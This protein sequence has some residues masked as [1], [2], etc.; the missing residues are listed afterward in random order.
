MSVVPKDVLK[1]T[2]PTK[3]FLC[4]L[5]DNH[6]G[7]EFLEFTIQDYD[8]KRVIFHVDRD[9]S[10]APDFDSSSNFDAD[11]L[12][13]IDYKFESDV[14]MLPRVQ[15]KL[16]FKVGRKKVRQF[17]MIERHYFRNRLIKSFD[18]TFPFCVPGSTNTWYSEYEL[19]P[20]DNALID[21]I[22]KRPYETES[23][24]FYF[25]GN[26]LIMHNKARYHYFHTEATKRRMEAKSGGGGG[27]K[28][29]GGAAA[30]ATAAASA[31]VTDS[32]GGGK[33]DYDDDA[34][35][36]ADYDEKADKFSGK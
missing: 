28:T 34:G 6:V 15:T 17:R 7:I 23:D 5:E 11:S 33:D 16:K 21:E 35:K 19:P 22:V 1:F 24:S 27:E 25:V 31:K 4:R 18:F 32:G 2:S 12:R 14:L 13:R 8:T 29:G 3:K 30:A 9:T 36:E 20:M 10:A 26:E